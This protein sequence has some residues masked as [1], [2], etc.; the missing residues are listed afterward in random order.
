MSPYSVSFCTHAQ[1]QDRETKASAEK[2][3]LFG[4][5]LVRLVLFLLVLALI[6]VFVT[7]AFSIFA[8]FASTLPLHHHLP[9]PTRPPLRC[10]HPYPAM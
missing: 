6:F 3:F 5:W 2:Q 9:Q 10:S 1:K 7:F 4:N 8:I